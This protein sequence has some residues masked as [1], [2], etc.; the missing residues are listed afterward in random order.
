MLGIW[1]CAPGVHIYRF[2]E[3]ESHDG[4]YKWKQWVTVL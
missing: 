4:K 3:T 1:W 2:R